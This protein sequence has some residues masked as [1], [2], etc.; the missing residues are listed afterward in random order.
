LSKVN[1]GLFNDKK[2]DGNSDNEVNDDLYRQQDPV[3]LFQVVHELNALYC[4]A[5]NLQARSLF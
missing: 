3:F 5:T 1:L 4:K 2:S